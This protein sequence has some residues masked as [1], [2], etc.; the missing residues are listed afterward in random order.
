MIRK[1]HFNK[2]EK[3]WL[4]AS[5]IPH[6]NGIDIF[7]KDITA[8]KQKAVEKELKAFLKWI[9]KGNHKRNF[10][11]EHIE[12]DYAD[13]LNKYVSVGDLEAARWYAERYLGI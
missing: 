5:F 8:A 2:I 13:V 11:F 12:G 6:L 10:N 9:R 3:K 1:C 4:Q 7:L